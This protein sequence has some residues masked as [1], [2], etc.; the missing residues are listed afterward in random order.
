M[1]TNPVVD[2]ILDYCLA[3]QEE[4]ASAPLQHPNL[5]DN[6]SMV[7]FISC[8]AVFTSAWVLGTLCRKDFSR[9]RIELDEPEVP[10]EIQYQKELVAAREGNVE[11]ELTEARKRELHLC[12]VEDDTPRGRV[13]MLY[14]DRSE[15]FW[16][17]SDN[18]EIPYKYLETLCRKYVLAFDCLELYHGTIDE[19]R[20][21]HALRK[22]A[23]EKKKESTEGEEAD[24]EEMD[25]FVRF[26]KYNRHGEESI[27][28]DDAIIPEESNRY[29][30]RGKMGDWEELQ[31]ARERLHIP[32]EDTAQNIDFATFKRMQKAGEL[33]AEK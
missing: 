31:R 15:S 8:A 20:R 33:D 3:H 32:Q 21:L 18:K 24:G 12:H 28:G 17:F 30:Y 1:S 27:G 25:V 26:K 2:S 9:A 19:L 16:W 23:A 22:E 11:L 5:F 7:F 13:V 29:S 14:D 4:C 6:I 10:Y